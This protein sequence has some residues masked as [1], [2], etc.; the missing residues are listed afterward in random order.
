MLVGLSISVCLIVCNFKVYLHVWVSLSV[1]LSVCRPGCLLLLQFKN[2]AVGK[3]FSLFVFVSIWF[4][5]SLSVLP[6]YD[7]GI[8]NSES[9]G[10]ISHVH[11]SSFYVP[12]NLLFC[13]KL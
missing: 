6:E 10:F 4:S 8:V 12:C 1:R 3:S 13:C 11:L 2:I 9:V 7:N 5:E